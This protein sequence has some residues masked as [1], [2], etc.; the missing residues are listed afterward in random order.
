MVPKY[1]AAESKNNSALPVL[2]GGCEKPPTG[3]TGAG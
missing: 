1:K 3:K 2:A